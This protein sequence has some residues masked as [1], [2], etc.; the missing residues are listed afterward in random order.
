MVLSTALQRARTV[1]ARSGLAALALL[2]AACAQEEQVGRFETSGE[3]IALSGADAGAR[4]ACILCHGLD[5]GGDGNLVPRLAGLDQGYLA[6]QL[7]F[8]AEGQRR[9][10]QMVWIS[11]HL[12]WPARQ[13]VAEYYS[14]MPVPPTP[15]AWRPDA[16]ACTR[17][18]AALYHVGD[19]SRGLQACATC[20]GHDGLG[21]GEGN[22]P[23]AGQ[24]A[25]YLAHQ[26]EAWRNGERYGDPLG[27]MT[28]VSRLL[29]EPE[30][31]A[32]AGYSSALQGANQYPELPA[33]CR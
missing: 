25:P 3:L 22:P 9:H 4:G 20:H 18:I 1:A 33:A 29:A 13:Q 28:H 24:P 32:L 11:D 17:P 15:A 8:Y 2:S 10:E 6:R 21:V 26:L 7:E 30:V 5:G 31:K 14:A 19:A 27:V 16:Q 12:D 23:L